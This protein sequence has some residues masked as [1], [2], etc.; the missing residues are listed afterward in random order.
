L[1]T[2]ALFSVSVLAAL[3]GM[4]ALSALGVD[5]VTFAADVLPILRNSCLNCHNP[6][7]HKA[8]LD[9]TTYQALMQGSDSGK[10]IEPGNPGNSLMLKLIMHTDEPAMPPKSDKLPDSQIAVIHKWIEGYALETVDSK[11]A[12]TAKNNASALEMFAEDKP[13]GPPPMP[14]DLLLEPVV[15]TARAGTIVSLSASPRAPVVAVAAQ[16]QVLL[17]NTATLELAGVLPFQEGFPAVVR[18]SRDGRL[19]I[20]GGGIGAKS[21]HV[22]VWDVV[23]GKR[24]LEVGDE[25]DA[26]L[27]ADISP[28]HHFIALGGP[29]RMVKIFRDGKLVHSIK[30]HTDWVTALAFTSDGKMLISGDRQGGVCVWEVSTGGEMFTLPSHKAGVTAVNAPGPQACITASEDGTIKMWDLREGKEVKSWNAHKSGTLAAAFSPDG[31]LV[32]CGRDKVVRLWDRDG[33][34]IKDFEA[35]SD[36]ALSAAICQDRI[37]AGDWT[38]AIRVWST[39]GKRLAEL[40][41][42]PPMLADRLTAVNERLTGLQTRHETAAALLGDLEKA[43]AKSN[44][45]VRVAAQS[46]GEKEKEV[47]AAE[48]QLASLDK[49]FTDASALLKKTGGDYAQLQTVTQALNADLAKATAANDAAQRDQK[50]LEGTM[51]EKQARADKLAETAKA[52]QA[53]A[54]QQPGDQPLADAAAAAKADADKALEDLT[55]AQKS[56]TTAEA[57]TQRAKETLAKANDAMTGNKDAL[58]ADQKKMDEQT[59]A[60]EKSR[61]ELASAKDA[62]AKMKGEFGEM[63]KN[64]PP[65]AAQA[66]AAVQ[67]LA[68]AKHDAE[69]IERDLGLAKGDLAKWKA[70]QINVT[71]Y[72]ARKELADRQADSARAV[73]GAQEA[74]VELDKAKADLSSARKA[75]GEAP[76]RIKAKEQGIVQAHA[77]MDKANADAAIAKEAIAHKETLIPPATD[78]ATRLATEAGQAADNTTLKD[79]ASKA[80][81]TLDLL[82][83]DLAAAHKDADARNAVA[84]QAAENLAA[85]DKALAQAK[86]DADTGPA[87]I[88]KLTATVEEIAS[89]TADARTAAAKKVD[90]ANKPVTE[91]QAKVN[92][93]TRD[94]ENLCKEAQAA[95]TSVA[96]LTKK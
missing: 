62:F 66:E 63:S 20:A 25:F 49:A 57:D 94:Y 41:P 5:K 78:F 86:N 42:N 27:A 19:L 18:F 32:S 87:L 72:A 17:Y 39:E 7:K 82:N 67:K 22:V 44:D 1:K 74:S 91:A 48:T 84:K 92:A 29:G 15:R 31:K 81:D 10:I 60:V 85:A 26:V 40:T 70:A 8:G 9:M 50:A 95:Y 45:E 13:S 3:S 28:D 90:D 24:V 73:A 79:A 16:K 68:K 38:G 55:A 69:A 76:E 83:H 33:N 2:R 71:L 65:K 61:T 12:A 21:G 52:A 46:A 64:L 6:D 58:Q 35:F 36:V 93:I 53:K 80:K 89:R 23:T 75:L 30:K 11:A 43:V 54:E 88:T 14:Q 37:I 59:A 34:K 96:E 51:Q 47:K 4:Y 77:A 56:A